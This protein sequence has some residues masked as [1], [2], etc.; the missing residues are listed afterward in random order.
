MIIRPKLKNRTSQVSVG[1]MRT[2]HPIKRSA[3]FPSLTG[4]LYLLDD[5]EGSNL[6]VPLPNARSSLP[7]KVSSCPLLYQSGFME[8]PRASFQELAHLWMIC[9]FHCNKLCVT[10]GTHL[11]KDVPNGLKSSLVCKLSK[12]LPTNK[13][14][15][16]MFLITGFKID[17]DFSTFLTEPTFSRQ[18]SFLLPKSSQSARRSSST[19]RPFHWTSSKLSLAF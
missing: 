16:S 18:M 8:G 5:K 13:S 12:I 19:E 17:S 6:R 1:T 11:P 4:R 15:S 3:M 9:L 10:V 14:A 2:I 7:S